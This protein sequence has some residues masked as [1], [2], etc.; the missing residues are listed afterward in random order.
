M[1]IKHEEKAGDE[2]TAAQAGLNASEVARVL[3]TLEKRR[4]ERIAQAHGISRRV[5]TQI[6]NA[7]FVGHTPSGD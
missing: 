1:P 3:V 5:A 2:L 4:L 6:A 7:F